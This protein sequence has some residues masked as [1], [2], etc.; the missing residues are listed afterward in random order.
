MQG[1]ATF[2][3]ALDG[4]REGD[5]TLLDHTVLFAHS[6]TAFARGHTLDGIPMMVAGLGSGRLK[7]GIHVAGNGEVATRAGFTMLQAMKVPAERF[8]G[9][10]MQTSKALREILV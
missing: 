1:L 4:I 2:V 8:G 7:G 9:G 10:S 3:Q 5:G 6:D